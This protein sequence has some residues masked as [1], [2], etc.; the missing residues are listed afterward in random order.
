MKLSDLKTVDQVIADR[1]TDDPEFAS[2]WD[3]SA[4]AR[5]V[6]VAVVRYREGCGMSQRD[7]ARAT[8]I[9]QPAIAR[10]ENGEHTPTFPTLAKLTAGTGLAFHVDVAAGGV[11]LVGTQ[12]VA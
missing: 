10:L 11:D 9:K 6:A 12:L 8:G 1:R 4:F 3:A 5:K 2:A 7:L